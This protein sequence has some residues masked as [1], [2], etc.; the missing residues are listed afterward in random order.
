MSNGMHMPYR[1]RKRTRQF[2]LTTA[3]AE[4]PTQITRE[5]FISF[6]YV[7][8]AIEFGYMFIPNS[9]GELIKTPVPQ[10]VRESGILPEGY[11][12]EFLMD[13]YTMVVAFAERNVTDIRQLSVQNIENIRLKVCSPCNVRIVPKRL[14]D[15]KLRILVAMIDENSE[16]ARRML[17][18]A[19]TN[20]VI[21]EYGLSIKNKAL[22]LKSPSK[23]FR[24]A[25]NR[26]EPFSDGGGIR[27]GRR[28]GQT[29]PL[30]KQLGTKNTTLNTLDGAFVQRIEYVYRKPISLWR[31]LRFIKEAKTYA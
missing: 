3:E 8:N 17:H 15:Q 12:V 10:Y 11:G 1:P 22:T 18:D 13:P 26:R 23:R 19:D 25:N 24:D 14:A 7:R 21:S 4:S 31:V 30:S 29:V 27:V 2:P 6:I 5:T 16:A 28:R 9:Q 20:M